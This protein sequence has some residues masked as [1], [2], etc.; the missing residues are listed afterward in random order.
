MPI[1]VEPL[2]QSP[3]AIA[4]PRV[5]VSVSV[6]LTEEQHLQLVWLK[7]NIPNTSIRKIIAEAINEKIA[8]L[9]QKHYR[10]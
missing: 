7:Q 2:P 9:L 10:P 6:L 3:W 4:H 8:V 1:P 5:T